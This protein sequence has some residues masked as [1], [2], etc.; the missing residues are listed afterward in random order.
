MDALLDR[1]YEDIN[2]SVKNK[3]RDY[4]VNVTE[5]SSSFFVLIKK[6]RGNILGEKQKFLFDNLKEITENLDKEYASKSKEFG[7]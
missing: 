5:L 2:F 7:R 3:F 1:F 4:V 6:F